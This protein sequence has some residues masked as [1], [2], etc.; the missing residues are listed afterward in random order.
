MDKFKILAEEVREHVFNQIIPFWEGLKDERGG[1]CGFVGRDLA[2]DFSAPKGGILTS[3]IL[4]FFSNAY[5]A[6]KSEK[7]ARLAKHAYEF[8]RDVF[9]DK[10]YGGVYW[11]VKDNKPDDDMKHV[12]CQ[13]FSVYA[14]ASYYRAFGETEALD[15][16]MAQFN[17]IEEKGKDEYGYLE[18]LNRD[19]SPSDDNEKL[20]EDGYD[21]KKTMNTLL[22][23]AEA[24]TELYLAN[25]DGRVKAAL[26]ET[27]RLTREK[28]YN[29]AK[30]QLEV[31]FDEKYNPISDIYSY[32]HDIEASWL[33]DRAADALGDTSFSALTSLLCN[34]VLA[35]AFDGKALYNQKLR[36]EIDKTRIWWVQAETIVGAL[37][38]YQKNGDE[39]LLD[40][41]FAVWEFIK[42]YIIDQKSGEWFWQTDEFGKPDNEP[43]VSPWKCPYHNG[44]M[45]LEVIS[46]YGK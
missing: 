38:E 24:Y 1:F 33:I 13:A 19:F 12:Y 6:Q 15:L 10:E 27:L 30:G 44:R 23:V 14:L 29:P 17:L 46:R 40:A 31:F 41:A 8:L 37:N 45:C 43:F 34:N 21:A 20:S 32:G 16:A 28:V 18:A 11:T 7:T 22:H 3:R 4:W 35:E 5:M 39:K 9:L 26:A 25:K 36:G 2:K 42:K